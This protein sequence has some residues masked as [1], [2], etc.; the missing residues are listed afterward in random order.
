M[1]EDI[2]KKRILL[3]KVNQEEQKE[4]NNEEHVKYEDENLHDNYNE[5]YSHQYNNRIKQIEEEIRTKL[6]KDQSK[7]FYKNIQNRLKP[8]VENELRQELRDDVINKMRTE[9]QL[10]LS[11]EFEERRRHELEKVKK[12]AN[13]NLQKKLESFNQKEKEKL[14]AE[15]MQIFQEKLIERENAFKDEYE[16]KLVE[17][18][19]VT[20]IKLLDDYETRTKQLYVE[21]EGLKEEINNI[22]QEEKMNNKEVNSKQIEF[23]EREDIS[24]KHMKELELAIES[25]KINKTSN[26]KDDKGF[27]PQNQCL[28]KATHNY[29]I[30]DNTTMS[31]KTNGILVPNDYNDFQHF[32]EEYVDNEREYKALFNNLKNK[33]FS[34]IKENISLLSNKKLYETS[35]FNHNP[36]V[37]LDY[38]LEI[39]NKIDLCYK[40]RYL[41]L[42]FIN[43]SSLIDILKFL[44]EETQGLTKYYKETEEVINLI[45]EKEKIK[46]DISKVKG[47]TVSCSRLDDFNNEIRNK[48]SKLKKEKNL[49]IFWKG[50]NYEYVSYLLIIIIISL[51]V[52]RIGLEIGIKLLINNN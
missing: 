7:E 44:D 51:C 6:I 27:I 8:Q 39:W 50:L 2:K 30:I 26:Y 28:S 48:I 9:I 24:N 40:N 18:K 5:D 36:I 34:M 3:S 35:G 21:Y 32:I 41:V 29:L 20:K 22:K 31:L 17:Y 45:R 42:D 49:S 47:I 38:L 10:S 19:K 13:M 46:Y 37:L 33:V 11:T 52:M 4:D 14:R 12:K 1:T 43:K 15:M 25:M 16:K 23:L